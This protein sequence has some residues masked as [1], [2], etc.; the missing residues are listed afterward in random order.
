[1][2]SF[3]DNLVARSMGLEPGLRPRVPSLF[4][5]ET[6][7][8]PGLAPEPAGTIEADDEAPGRASRRP[9]DVNP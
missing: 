8:H 5:P 6:S 2:R 3:L 7:A 9:G 4:A 1:M